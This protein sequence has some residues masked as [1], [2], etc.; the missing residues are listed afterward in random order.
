MLWQAERGEQTIQAICQ[1]HSIAE[2]TF[3]RWRNVYGGMS[4]SEAQRLKGCR[5]KNGRLMRPLAERDPE[6]AS[7]KEPRQ[8]SK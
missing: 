7:L 2:T 4:V 1:E 8:K 3:Y 5:K 6:V